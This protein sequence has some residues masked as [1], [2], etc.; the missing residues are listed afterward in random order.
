MN[1]AIGRKVSW[2]EGGGG[3]GLLVG[4]SVVLMGILGGGLVL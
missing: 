1:A 4:G 3:I 2:G